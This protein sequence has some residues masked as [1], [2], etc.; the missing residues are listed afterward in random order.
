MYTSRQYCFA[1]ILILLHKY[2]KP[3]L[4]A[5]GSSQSSGE[6]TQETQNLTKSVITSSEEGKC[7]DEKCEDDELIRALELSRQQASSGMARRQVQE[8]EELRE[9]IRISYAMSRHVA[10]SSESLVGSPSSEREVIELLDD[11]NDEDNDLQLALKRSLETARADEVRQTGSYSPLYN[12]LS[13][14]EFQKCFDEWFLAQGGIDKVEKGSIVQ[15]GNNWNDFRRGVS[16]EDTRN[17]ERAQY[18]R[19]SIPALYN[20]LDSLTGAL[21]SSGL[22]PDSVGKIEVFEDIG[23]GKILDKANVFVCLPIVSNYLLLSIFM[24]ALESRCCRQHLSMD[25][26]REALKS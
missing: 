11:D 10:C 5:N 16:K 22:H 19:L 25:S 1:Q 12:N 23:M 18:G 20:I 4:D 21:T 2:Q 26:F 13:R 17:Q 6:S 9:A 15:E 8:D 24:Q 3:S 7:T 14:D